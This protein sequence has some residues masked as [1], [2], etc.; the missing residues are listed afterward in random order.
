MVICTKGLVGAVKKCL[1]DLRLLDFF[2]EVYGNVGGDAYGE[3]PFDK[4][5]AQE[6]ILPQ[7][8]RL[9][10]APQQ[11]AWRT[12]AELIAR[13]LS[14]RRL[15]PQQAVLVEDDPEEIR[16]ANGT[17][18][19]YF[20]REAQG[21]TLE[22]LS[23]L[24]QMTVSDGVD[25]GDLQGRGPCNGV[26]AGSD[27][28]IPRGPQRQNSGSGSAIGM[29]YTDSDR[30]HRGL[31]PAPPGVPERHSVHSERRSGGEPRFPVPPPPPPPRS[32]A[33]SDGRRQ[34]PWNNAGGSG[35]SSGSRP[36]SGEAN[37][38][39]ASG[40]AVTG[41]QQARPGMGLRSSSVPVNQPLR[42]GGGGAGGG[43]GVLGGL[44]A[45]ALAGL[46]GFGSFASKEGQTPPPHSSPAVAQERSALPQASDR[47][48]AAM[49]QERSFP[50]PLRRG[51]PPRPSGNSY[52]GGRD[53]NGVRLVSCRAELS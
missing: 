35:G 41:G 32:R 4:S 53:M 22:D 7:E 14:Q 28:A 3:T 16:K 33:P 8:A 46:C 11:G 6:Q 40:A 2:G 23:A 12:K 47:G 18:R 24:V 19:T 52:N 9:L 25:S 10:G 48:S 43:G 15:R 5:V 27:G 17:C 50:P 49:S 26:H 39:V 45:S 20:V 13:L 1:I 51:Q 31:P 37:P 36:A 38:L 21:V 44:S 42:G 34:P 30:E 29:G